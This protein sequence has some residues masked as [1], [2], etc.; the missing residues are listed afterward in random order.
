MKEDT[1]RMVEAYISVYT[2]F[3]AIYDD[4]YGF[5]GNKTDGAIVETAKLFEIA[6]NDSI[7]GELLKQEI[8]ERFME[9]KEKEQEEQPAQG[10]V[11][12]VHLKKNLRRIAPSL[13]REGMKP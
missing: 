11:F 12:K 7:L 5:E 8:V 3:E 1:R 6:L 2:E 4:I 10:A 9:L 13:F